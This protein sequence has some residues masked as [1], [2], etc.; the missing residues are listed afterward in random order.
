MLID[1]IFNTTPVVFNCFA[2]SG[3]EATKSI[4]HEHDFQGVILGCTADVTKETTIA[5]V[6]AGANGVITKPLQLNSLGESVAYS[7]MLVCNV[8]HTHNMVLE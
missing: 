6:D 8:N 1:C 7:L 5:F 2:S 3:L 4:R